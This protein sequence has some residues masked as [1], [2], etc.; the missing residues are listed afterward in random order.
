MNYFC[1]KMSSQNEALGR[2]VEI[3]VAWVM[4]P[5]F[6]FPIHVNCVKQKATK[7]WFGLV[8]STFLINCEKSKRSNFPK[9][10]SFWDINSL[11]LLFSFAQQTWQ[12]AKVG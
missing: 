8:G 2:A 7:V 3:E 12:Y 4:S 6:I 10:S 11:I 1:G 5:F 9:A